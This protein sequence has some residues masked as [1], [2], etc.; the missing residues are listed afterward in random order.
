[1]Q[2]LR[3]RDVA[4]AVGQLMSFASHELVISLLFDEFANLSPGFMQS[5][6]GRSHRRIGRYM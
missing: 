1:M 5:R 3:R 4:Y 6:W 2:A